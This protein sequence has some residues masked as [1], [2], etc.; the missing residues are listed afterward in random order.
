MR[1]FPGKNNPAADVRNGT[2]KVDIAERMIR[3]INEGA[4][5]R[6]VR[7]LWQENLA[8]LRSCDVV[9]GCIDGLIPRLGLEESCRRAMIPLIDI[10]MDVHPGLRSEEHT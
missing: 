1:A 9:F 2:P 4:Q 10:G 8:L 5:V 3:S 7:G 6:P